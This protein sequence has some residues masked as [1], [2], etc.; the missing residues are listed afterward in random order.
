[1]IED[2]FMQLEL[3]SRAS[4]VRQFALHQRAALLAVLFVIALGLR[5]YQIGEPPLDFHAT[6]QYRSLLIARSF[7]YESLTTLPE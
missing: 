4:Q 3:S 5:F 1:L 7:Y 6:R 2:L